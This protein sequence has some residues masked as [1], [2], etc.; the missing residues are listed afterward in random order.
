[1]PLGLHVSNSTFISLRPMFLLRLRWLTHLSL[2]GLI[3]C[4]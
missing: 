2:L 3:F 4:T 1:M